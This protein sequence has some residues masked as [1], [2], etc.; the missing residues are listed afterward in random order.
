MDSLL[1]SR[2]LFRFAADCRYFAGA[3]SAT[4]LALSDD[5]RL[6]NFADLEETRSYADVRAGWN[7]QGLYFAVAVTGKRSSVWCRD[8]KPEDSDGLQ[9]F[10]DTRDTH[11]IHRASRF[12]H[13][14]LFMP[15]GTGRQ[16]AEPLADQLLVDRARENATPVRPGQL[17]VHA[18][19]KPDGYRLS[20]MIPAGALTGFNPQDNPRLGF[21]Y[22]LLDR[23]LGEQTFSCGLEFPFPSD[24]SLWGTLQMR[25]Q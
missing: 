16:Y 20:A 19:V 5:H 1:A 2:M 11:N 10:I 8:N 6:P 17:R 25:P 21:T 15:A 7:E 4:G 22:L 18:A 23:E 12:C 14:F 9:L 24:P 13:R 3:W